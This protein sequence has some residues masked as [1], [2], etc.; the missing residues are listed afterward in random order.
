MSDHLR[1]ERE[2]TRILNSSTNENASYGNE[3]TN[4]EIEND[5]IEEAEDIRVL[6]IDRLMNRGED[7]RLLIEES[8]NLVYS[9]GEP[10]HKEKKKN[11]SGYYMYDYI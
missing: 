10:F 5:R 3:K 6:N 7:I 8:E 1:H 11:I 2:T 4:K 9:G